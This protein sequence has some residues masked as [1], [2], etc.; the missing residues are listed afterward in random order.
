[1]SNKELIAKAWEYQ[2]AMTGGED[3]NWT[4][5]VNTIVELRQALEAAQRECGCGDGG[6]DETHLRI[7]DAVL[8]W[9]RNRRPQDAEF[10]RW[11]AAHDAQ[12]RA[13]TLEEAA[14]I[15]EDMALG[16]G[17]Y[18]IRNALRARAASIREGQEQ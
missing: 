8:E 13:D 17:Y 15:A 2:D 9:E 10:D 5:A 7:A 4:G 14:V 18:G 12:V 6:F 11:L 1:M 16:A 3:E